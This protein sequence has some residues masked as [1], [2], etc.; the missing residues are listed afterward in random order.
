LRELADLGV[1]EEKRVASFI[2]KSGVVYY[3][4]LSKNLLRKEGL[5]HRAIVKELS[6][7]LL[8]SGYKPIIYSW[9]RPDAPDIAL[10][11]LRIAL[12]VETGQK[13]LPKMN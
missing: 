8:Q 10:E 2:K 3:T 13:K 11:E 4:S 12:E 6:R 7:F 5:E 9:S 1:V